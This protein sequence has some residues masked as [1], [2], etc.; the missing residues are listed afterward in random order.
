M[1]VASSLGLRRAAAWRTLLDMD[2]TGRNWVATRAWIVLLVALVVMCAADL[3]GPAMVMADGQHCAGPACETQVVC[4]Q[5]SQPQ[6]S[7]GAPIQVIAVPASGESLVG[8][9]D[10]D[11][12]MV[13]PPLATLPC[14]SFGPLASRSPPAV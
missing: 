12:R 10:T 13:D 11:T 6:I 3:T 5:P 4:G 8:P 2:S 1:L 14:T 9:V 7:S